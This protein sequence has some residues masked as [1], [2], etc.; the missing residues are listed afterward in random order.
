MTCCRVCVG[1]VKLAAGT[2]VGG[3]EID[4]TLEYRTTLSNGMMLFAFGGTGTY[5][6]LGLADGALLWKLSVNGVETFCTFENTPLSLCD[7]QWH[8][9]RKGLMSIMKQLTKAVYD[10]AVLRRKG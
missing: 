6:I 10:L 2:F 3:R 5:F 1:Y 4:I 9:V 8:T 7:G